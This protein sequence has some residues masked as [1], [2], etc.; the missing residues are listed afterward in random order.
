MLLR[1]N[2]QTADFTP[3][4]SLGSEEY[5]RRT[6]EPTMEAILGMPEAYRNLVDEFGYI[7]IYRAWRRGMHPDM[8][9]ARAKANNGV[10]TL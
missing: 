4:G 1:N 2:S 3:R 5:K 8:I 6:A 7:D 10:F 9:R